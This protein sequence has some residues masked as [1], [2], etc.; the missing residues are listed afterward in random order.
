MCISVCQCIKDL[1]DDKVS[2][3]HRAGLGG[4]IKKEAINPTFTAGKASCAHCRVLQGISV[5]PG[6]QGVHTGASGNAFTCLYCRKV[7]DAAGLNL[8]F[9]NT[10]NPKSENLPFQ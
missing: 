10:W 7:R 1:V 4:C 8:V 2:S 9:E 6:A 5:V 3:S